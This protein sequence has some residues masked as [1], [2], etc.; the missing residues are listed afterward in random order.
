MVAGIDVKFM[1]RALEL[2][3]MA[4]GKT[5]PNPAVGAVIVCDGKIIGEGYHTKAGMPH[6]EVNA[7]NA[8][9]AELLGRSTIYVTLEPCSHHG[10][11]PPCADLLVEKG[12]KRVVVG[13]T[14]TSSKVSGRGIERLRSGGCEVEVGV[15][16]EECRWLNRRF[17]TL[18]EKGRPWVILKWAESSDGYIDLAARP[19]S[20]GVN[21]I[22][23]L[24]ERTLV[25][26]W[27]AQEDA[28]LVG[29]NTVLIDDPSLDVRHV[30]GR[31]P[32]RVVL[33]GSKPLPKGLK[34]L[35]DDMPLLLFSQGSMEMKAG[36]E[37]IETGGAIDP[38]EVLRYLAG[39]GVSSVI[40]EGGANTLNRFI[41]KGMWDEARVFRG[42]GAFGG[43][44]AAP[45][46]GGRIVKSRVF[47]SST[48][49]ITVN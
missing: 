29:R 22:T 33:A 28:I 44:V 36:K 14:D 43:G 17:F 27:R 20:S 38:E 23:G 49:T 19:P 9:P 15:L 30:E 42:K 24:E 13:T 7:V 39:R 31:N 34:I 37:V 4:E 45:V 32:L 3:A 46:A 2:A 5:S 6:A 12:F 21:W 48:L 8:A 47:A 18:N 11:T 1:E 35:E 41:E 40:V 25:H 26:R 16:E 10:R